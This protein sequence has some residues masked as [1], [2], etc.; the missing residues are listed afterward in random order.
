MNDQE[1]MR[2]KM[3]AIGARYLARTETEILDLQKMIEQL[4]VASPST[5]NGILKEIEVLSHRIRGSGAVFGYAQLSDAAG[6]I[7][8]LAVDSA[9]EDDLDVARLSIQ[10]ANHLDALSVATHGALQATQSAA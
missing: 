7:E 5:R 9:L 1:E 10:F 3:A 8:M 2:R 6:V 4:A